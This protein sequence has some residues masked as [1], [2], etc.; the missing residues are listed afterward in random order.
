MHIEEIGYVWCRVREI[1]LLNNS[2]NIFKNDIEIVT[3][4]LFLI[5]VII[6]RF[7]GDKKV[8]CSVILYE[9]SVNTILKAFISLLVLF[10]SSVVNDSLVKVS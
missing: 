10:C 7:S 2:D 4:G 6:L 8:Y 3:D 9:F 5:K 1:Y